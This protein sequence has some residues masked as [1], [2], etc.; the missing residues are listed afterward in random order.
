MS[1]VGTVSCSMNR[2]G[3]ILSPISML[4]M[5]ITSTCMKVEP[6]VITEHYRMLF[7]LKGDTLTTR[8]IHNDAVV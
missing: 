7:S 4:H 3:E 1:K 5:Q 8:D 2:L 6:V